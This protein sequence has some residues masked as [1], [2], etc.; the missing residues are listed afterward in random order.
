[1]EERDTGQRLFREAGGEAL[2]DGEKKRV[3][4]KLVPANSSCRPRSSGHRAT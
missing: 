3:V 4:K 2:R 1:M